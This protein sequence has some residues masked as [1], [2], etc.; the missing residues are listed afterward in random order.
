MTFEIRSNGR[1]PGAIARHGGLITRLIGTGA[2]H[3]Q[4]KRDLDRLRFSHSG[5][6]LQAD[7][8]EV[9]LEGPRHC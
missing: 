8:I 6:E 7:P 4:L 1:K 9:R 2:L 3:E 5:S